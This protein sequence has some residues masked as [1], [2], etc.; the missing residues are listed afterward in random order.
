MRADLEEFAAA[1]AKHPRGGEPHGRLVGIPWGP[2]GPIAAM[3]SELPQWMDPVAFA[4]WDRL[5]TSKPGV[6]MG[7]TFVAEDGEVT[8]VV[9]TPPKRGDALGVAAHEIVEVLHL[10]Q[11]QADGWEYPKA[12]RFLLGVI[13]LD[14]YATER[15]RLETAQAL[16]WPG[17]VFHDTAQGL[18]QTAEDIE[19]A[20]PPDRKAYDP[21]QD[22]WGWWQTMAMLWSHDCARAPFFPFVAKELARWSRCAVIADDGWAPVREAREQIYEDALG[23]D[24]ETERAAEEI[25][26]PIEKYARAVW[27]S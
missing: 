1:L 19:Q 23:R 6:T 5:R 12:T 14:E 16:N 13:M 3:R 25:W 7:K 18:V 21:G 17:S 11:H 2:S 20:L 24:E 15:V 4:K 9:C 26:D 22:F 10:S 27:F 8:A